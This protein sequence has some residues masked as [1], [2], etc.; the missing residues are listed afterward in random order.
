MTKLPGPRQDHSGVEHWV[1]QS[2]CLLRPLPEPH[3]PSLTVKVHG[4]IQL[5]VWT[6]KHTIY[7]CRLTFHV[8]GHHQGGGDSS[9]LLNSC[10][11]RQK[12]LLPIIILL[13]SFETRS[14]SV[15]QAGLHLVTHQGVGIT[16]M[17]PPHTHTLGHKYCFLVL[18]VFNP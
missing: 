17:P 16:V 15:A 5:W 9:S 3:S 4:R 7:Q 2:V 8:P 11:P 10:H 6:V 1:K 14:L 18:M 13:C 12:S